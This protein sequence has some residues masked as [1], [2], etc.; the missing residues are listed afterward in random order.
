MRGARVMP[1][2]LRWYWLRNW[3]GIT[4]AKEEACQLTEIKMAWMQQQLS[5]AKAEG[6]RHGD[7]GNF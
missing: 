2:G 5:Q 4:P 7:H 3:L 1:H 6:E